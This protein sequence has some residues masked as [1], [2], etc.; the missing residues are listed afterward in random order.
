MENATFNQISYFNQTMYDF[1]SELSSVMDKKENPLSVIDLEDSVYCI[2]FLNEIKKDLVGLSNRDKHFLQNF[3]TEVL[4][5]KEKHF[6][7]SVLNLNNGNNIN[8]IWKFFETLTL[9]SLLF[10]FETET[11]Q[12]IFDSPIIWKDEVF[13]VKNHTILNALDI[14]KMDLDGNFLIYSQEDKKYFLKIYENL[15]NHRASKISTLKNDNK[16][17]LNAEEPEKP[18]KPEISENPNNDSPDSPE[19]LYENFFKGTKIGSLANDIAQDLDLSDLIQKTTN[20]MENSGGNKAPDFSMF[21]NLMKDGGIMNIVENVSSKL[22]TK[23][24]GGAVSQEELLSEVS[25]LM[26]KMKSSNE[27]KD[28]FK[29][30]DMSSAMGEMFKASGMSG[31]EG[32]E[33]M[34]KNLSNLG[35]GLG[36][37]GDLGSLGGLAGLAKMG[38]F[39]NEPQ[40]DDD[41]DALENMFGGKED[42][43]QEEQNT[44]NLDMEKMK[45]IMQNM[46]VKSNQSSHSSKTKDRLRQKL[47]NKNSDKN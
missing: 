30:G 10:V 23:I 2:N 5:F 24:D 39:G 1:I 41:F 18:E 16:D 36:G 3:N 15:K 32:S 20:L 14:K 42:A 11:I 8:S 17:L 44:P 7:K 31:M 34:L 45:E 40:N 13:S 27:F 43:S 38:G 9:I 26:G 47:K 33:D 6:F 19:K 22:K 12:N 29:D 35:G 37:L 4:M 28:V 46:N 25:G 21:C